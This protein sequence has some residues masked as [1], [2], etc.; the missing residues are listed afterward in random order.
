MAQ[1]PV[2]KAAVVALSNA[3]GRAQMGPD[4]EEDED[5][6][7]EEEEEDDDEEDKNDDYHR[8]CSFDQ[9]PYFCLV[10]LGFSDVK[11]LLLLFVTL[12]EVIL[13]DIILALALLKVNKA[14]YQ[15]H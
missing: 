8:K 13:V 11:C 5:Y 7:S 1:P 9:I 6:D 4:T 3:E 2:E 10:I 15:L 14:I 12:A